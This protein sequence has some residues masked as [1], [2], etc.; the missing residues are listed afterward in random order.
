MLDRR[1]FVAVAI[2]VLT[3]TMLTTPAHAQAQDYPKQKITIVV[4]F[5]AGGSLDT[6]ARLIGQKLS[7]R[8][9]QP[10]VVENRVGAGGNI[11]ARSVIA[12]EPDGYTLLLTS[13][14]VAI[15]QSLHAN[16]GYAIDDL[17]PIIFPGVNTSILAVNPANPAQDLSQL[18]ANVRGKSLTF[19]SAGV[20]TGGHLTGEYF[21]KVLAKVDAV[22]TPFA[23]GAPAS[24]ALLG[25]HIDAISVAIP[26]VAGQIKSGA[27]RGLAV[28][29]LKRAGAVPDVKTFAEQGFPGFEAIAWSGLFAPAK[30]N[31]DICL[32]LNQAMNEIMQEGEVQE[33]MATL[34]FDLNPQ[35]LPQ[36]QAFLKSE[37]DKWSAIVRALG[38][39]IN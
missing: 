21:F 10:V 9:G 27:L 23:G 3:A 17:T 30:T 31:A 29:S 8:W 35:T 7:A 15:N 38:I 14:G 2:A 36:A 22:H 28:A 16:P 4:A 39:K 5:A 13:T 33:R 32:K 11:G 25:N 19:G 1:L 20:G 24:S 18:L 34:G 12:S 37:L 26:D 6:L